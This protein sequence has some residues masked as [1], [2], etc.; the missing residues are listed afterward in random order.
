[1]GFGG[2]NVSLVACRLDIKSASSRCA[3]L[4]SA[5]FKERGMD[6]RCPASGMSRCN[7]HNL[8]EV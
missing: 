8:G 3:G 7:R 1:M 5:Y 4:A 6:E 2:L